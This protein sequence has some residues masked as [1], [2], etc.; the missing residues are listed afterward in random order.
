MSDLRL[1]LLF[2]TFLA[3]FIATALVTLLG[4]IGA[5]SIPSVQLSLLV[6]AFFVE[7]AGAV[8]ALFRRT[9]FFART[10]ENLAASIGAALEGLDR[11]SDEITATI[12]NVPVEQQVQPYRFLIRR[13][14]DSI[15]AYQ[16]MNVITGQ[17]LDQLPKR[18]RDLVKGYERAMRRLVRDWEGLKSTGAPT[19]QDERERELELLRTTKHNLV[20]L[21][22]F[23]QGL[24]IYLDD[25]Y[26]EVRALVS[27]L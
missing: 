18:Q 15:V 24:G 23:L 17:Q 9:D 27:R 22:D 2:Y 19:G 20:G 21:L 13:M 14:D 5:V 3:I 1:N 16:R 4:L 11:I 6:G 26:R 25:H 8:I 12:K 10:P 7:L